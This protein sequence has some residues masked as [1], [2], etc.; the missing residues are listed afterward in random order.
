MAIQPKYISEEE[1]YLVALI[2]DESGIDLAEFLWEDPTADNDEQLFRCWDFQY[3][4]WRN[5]FEQGRPLRELPKKTIDR[6]AR[7]VG[8]SASIILR[9]WAFPIQNPGAEAVVTAPELVHLQP[10]VSRIEDRLRETRLTRE[11]LPKRHGMGF[12]H[13]PFEVDFVNGAKILGR[14]PQR[15]GK[16]V[17]GLHPYHL[18]Q[19][20]CLR[21]G[22]LILTQ[23]GLLPIEDVQVGQYVLT[24]MNRWRKVSQVFDRGVRDAVK[25]V[26][27][28]WTP[29]IVST[30]DHPFWSQVAVK[31]Q[32]GGEG[33]QWTAASEMA[34]HYWSS[35]L[36]IPPLP[37]PEIPLSKTNVK[38][39]IDVSSEDF[40]RL[41]GWW[42]AEGSVQDANGHGLSRSTWSVHVDEVEI[43]TGLASR[44]GLHASVNDVASSDM[45]KNVV[46]NHS[47]LARWLSANFGRGSR[48]KSIPP[49]VFGMDEKLRRALF[50]GLIA[51]DGFYEKNA[52]YA[53]GRCKLSTASEKLAVSVRILAQGLG[54]HVSVYHNASNPNASIR[55]KKV[56]GNGWY[57]V[58]CNASGQG[59]DRDDQ[60]LTKVRRVEPHPPVQMFDLEVE[61]DHS[62]VAN[63]VIV[64]N[65]QDFP[66]AGWMELIETLKAGDE[67]SMW[68]AHGVSRGP[69]DEFF[70]HSQPGSGWVVH[71]ITGMHRPSWSDEERES[72]IQLYGSRDSSDY[73]RNILGEHGD[74]SNALFVMHRLMAT[75]D[76][77]PGSDYNVNDYYFRRISDEMLGEGDIL[78]MIDPPGSHKQWDITWGGMDVGMTD[79]PTE[80]LV[81]GEEPD[82]KKS[83]VLRLLTRIHLQRVRSSDQ[84]AVVE[85]LI[86]FYNMNLF[87]MDRGGVGFPLFQ[88]LQDGNPRLAPRIR[89]FTADEK[90]VVSYDEHDEFDDP[91]RFAVKRTAKELGYDTLRDFVDQQRIVLPWDRQLIGEWSG[92]RWVRLKSSTSPYGTKTFSRG[93]FHTLDAASMAVVGRFVQGMEG[94]VGAGDEGPIPMVFL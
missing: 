4:W 23:D 30:P 19:D 48:N 92:Q 80:I 72:K 41:A 79:A 39:P 87:T 8:K 78:N 22:T 50:E 35:P 12:R 7:A 65:S 69:G 28:G 84:R 45:C 90:V 24:H 85:F 88:E 1:A 38:R 74:S 94:E 42:L 44:I 26:G 81:F 76:D 82:K 86:D 20:E 93:E 60:R 37:I 17:K 21:S 71:Q 52:G 27:Q 11:L 32:R 83:S 54:Y 25:V 6:C 2:Q 51:G 15:D 47:E 55:G 58:V 29:G 36:E 9:M 5:T 40:M 89:G 46:I 64:H 59:I 13:R 63:G 34:G 61:D 67:G 75:V 68:R 33:W 53:E 66:L 57:Q 62:F 56:N 14:I 3:A 91:E 31:N 16:G 10:L 49:W 73:K 70:R 43:I 77:D 18:E